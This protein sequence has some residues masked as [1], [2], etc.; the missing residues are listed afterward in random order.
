MPSFGSSL[1]RSLSFTNSHRRRR[2]REIESSHSA[3][4]LATVAATTMDEAAELQAAQRLISEQ[5]Q[6]ASAL[7]DL[8][9]AV[10]SGADA[11]AILTGAGFRAI[12]E[13]LSRTQHEQVE[14]LCRDSSAAVV[15][16]QFPTLV[17]QA[18][19]L[20]ELL[21]DLSGAA[22]G[23]ATAPRPPPPPPPHSAASQLASDTRANPFMLPHSSTTPW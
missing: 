19:L 11:A 18:N 3:K 9:A 7:R 14:L 10:V 6:I 21:S 8:I 16:R 15:R 12:L 17:S 20:M 22:G 4:E 23:A 13:R 5:Q 1:V 2:Q